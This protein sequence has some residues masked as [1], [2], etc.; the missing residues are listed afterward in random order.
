MVQP[1][2]AEVVAN[3]LQRIVEGLGNSAE[4]GRA[5]SAAPATR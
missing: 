5:G 3:G 2:G 1:Q 4:I